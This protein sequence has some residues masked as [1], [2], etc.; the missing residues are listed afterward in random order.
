MSS[1]FRTH[2]IVLGSRDHLEADRYYSVLTDEHG[3]LELRAR[4]S[5]KISSKLS[6]HLE[7]FAL[8]DLMV[9]RGRFGDIVAGVERLELYPI[10]RVDAQKLELA[11]Q[12]FHLVEVGTRDR[13]PDEHLFYFL[14]MWLKFLNDAP[15][16]TEERSR[17]LLSAFTLRLLGY[18]GYRPELAMCVKC[19]VPVRHEAFR[20]H[21]LRGGVVCLSCVEREPEQ[22]FTS[23]PFC[24]ETLKLM[25]LSLGF[26]L[27]RLL[28]V[29]LP[30]SLLHEFHDAVDSLLIA[31]FPVIPLMILNNSAS[32]LSIDSLQ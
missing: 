1:T 5:R 25:R 14:R 23:R 11:M 22:W 28:D 26:P 29:R 13:Q 21:G 6:S 17:F 18:L 2:A 3:K 10:I 20:W 31:H 12:S 16:F 30:G 19:Q 4:G 32:H 15:S 7:P 9:V 27:L 8:C 24:D